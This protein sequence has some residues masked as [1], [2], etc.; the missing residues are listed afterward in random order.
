M[1]LDS[2]M[3][4]CEYVLS[5][6]HAHRLRKIFTKGRTRLPNLVE[7]RLS[8]SGRRRVVVSSELTKEA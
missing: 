3:R 4:R 5:P 2:K 7:D 6:I 8:S 1:K